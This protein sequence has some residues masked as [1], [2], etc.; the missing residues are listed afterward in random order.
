MIK[1]WG[2]A[3]TGLALAGW[4]VLCEPAEAQESRNAAATEAVFLD[5]MAALENGRPRQAI[6]LFRGILA[7][8]PGL[9]RVRLE[10]ARAYFMAEEFD[11]A[12]E[13]FL[14]VL[15]GDIPTEVR[16]TVAQFIREIDA[17]RGFDW[18]LEVSTGL[19]PESMRRG[20]SD[21]ID[22]VFLGQTRRFT[23]VEPEAP[24]FEVRANGSASFRRRL[25]DALGD[26]GAVGLI[27]ARSY[28]R[29]TDMEDFNELSLGIDARIQ[30]VWPGTTANAGPT[31]ETHWLGGQRYEDRY[32]VEVRADTRDQQGLSIFG[33][34]QGGWA[35]NR[36][37]D[38]LSGWTGKARMGLAQS[39]QGRGSV[40][41]VLEVDRRW[42][43]AGE[44]SY[45]EGTLTIFGGIDAGSGIR[46]DGRGFVS[47]LVFDERREIFAEK[48]QETEAGLSGR[49]TKTDW[50]V[51]GRFSPFVEAG[52]SRRSSTIDAFGYDEITLSFGFARAL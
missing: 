1:T 28:V 16:A 47:Q 30:G 12:R 8:D 24:T 42:S 49:A 18:S 35:E 45:T 6:A 41:V 32:F 34:A 33:G 38:A 20:H 10:L 39:I 11:L 22:L 7:R 17:R 13:E 5:G 3:L 43:E 51:L 19:A 29:R 44:D 27:T 46:L 26:G 2:W 48:R 52:I 4:T 36:S 9:V 37:T 15:S 21:Q 25:G 23:Y 14:A 31:I 40:G 50:F